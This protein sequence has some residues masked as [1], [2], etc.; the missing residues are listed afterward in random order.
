MGLESKYTRELCRICE[1]Q[2]AMTQVLIS[3]VFYDARGR[4]LGAT[5]PGWPDRIFTHERLTGTV[6]VEFKLQGERPSAL[7]ERI[8]KQLRER[9]DIVF[10]ASFSRDGNYV[11][12]DG[13]DWVQYSLFMKQ[14]I[15]ATEALR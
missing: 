13:C 9:G 8:H 2:G 7:Q 6:Y 5:S 15:N 11:G 3:G 4:V 10:V 12:I 1:Q 14:L